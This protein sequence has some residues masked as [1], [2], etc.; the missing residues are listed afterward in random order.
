LVRRAATHGRRW[1]WREKLLRARLAEGLKW[2]R[3]RG[4]GED[5]RWASPRGDGGVQP[6]CQ[7]RLRLGGRDNRTTWSFREATVASSIG[8]GRGGIAKLYVPD[9][10]GGCLIRARAQVIEFRHTFSPSTR[11]PF[12]TLVV[13]PVPPHHNT[14]RTHAKQTLA[15]LPGCSPG[16]H[17]PM[18]ACH[19][20]GYTIT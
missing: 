10:T 1:F 8:W 20:A 9:G 13:S 4:G 6:A 2:A 3:M 12:Q 16:M 5:L 15:D 14:S 7:R 19:A 18:H 17:A 11:L